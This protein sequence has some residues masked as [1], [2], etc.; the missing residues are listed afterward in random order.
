M[1]GGQQLSTR[2]PLPTLTYSSNLHV[3]QPARPCRYDLPLRQHSW[4]RRFFWRGV[5]DTGTSLGTLF[6][7]TSLLTFSDLLLL[8]GS[9]SDSPP[10]PLCL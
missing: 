8:A 10:G 2:R 6:Y 5:F 1:G 7:I 3:P 9:V 4:A